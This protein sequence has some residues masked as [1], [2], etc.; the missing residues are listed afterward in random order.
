[1]EVFTVLTALQTVYFK[2]SCKSEV[3]DCLTL[4]GFTLVSND[5]CLVVGG[6]DYHLF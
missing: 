3:I 1:M 5:V 4:Q 6:K 2:A